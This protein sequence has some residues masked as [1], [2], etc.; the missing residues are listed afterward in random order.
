VARP[1]PSSLPFSKDFL[2]NAKDS[3]GSCKDFLGIS[4]L[5]FGGFV[6]FQR[7]ARDPHP[8][9]PFQIFRPEAPEK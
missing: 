4:K 5:F 3:L 6:G 2:G 8:I 1:S 7:V 9:K